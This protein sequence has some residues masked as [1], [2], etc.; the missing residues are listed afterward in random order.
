VYCIGKLFAALR[1][2]INLQ[3][4]HVTNPR[5]IAALAKL[6]A[7]WISLDD[8]AKLVQAGN[9][10]RMLAVAK[11][12]IEK[13]EC[14]QSLAAI[15]E[16]AHA[17]KAKL[18]FHYIVLTHDLIKLDLKVF[19]HSEAASTVEKAAMDAMLAHAQQRKTALE[20]G[21]PKLRVW[22]VIALHRTLKKVDGFQDTQF[23]EA[24]Q[25][26]FPYSTYFN[27]SD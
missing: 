3:E 23:K 24:A 18:G 5:R 17:E 14:P 21:L 1:A 27:N 12:E 16:W 20:V 8:A 13:L 6:F 15:R 11:E 19:K 4:C 25:E 7:H 26:L 9:D 10:E 22:D 2:G